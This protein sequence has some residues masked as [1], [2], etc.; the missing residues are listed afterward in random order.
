MLTTARIIRRQNVRKME[1]PAISSERTSMKTENLELVV[2]HFR[3]RKYDQIF[4]NPSEFRI[5]LRNFS[6]GNYRI[7]FVQNFHIE[8]DN[9]DLDEYLGGIYIAAKK[10]NGRWEV[11][12][13]FPVECRTIDVIG[14]LH[15]E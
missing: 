6:P 8:D 4:Q 15:L 5:D 13:S 14:Y 9:P 12:E 11:P 1:F 3:M 7:V 10:K 2:P